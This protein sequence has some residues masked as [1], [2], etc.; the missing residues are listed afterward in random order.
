MWATLRGELRARLAEKW[1]DIEHFNEGPESRHKAYFEVTGDY[2]W[3]QYPRRLASAATDG[4]KILQFRDFPET[5]VRVSRG[6]SDSWRVT[7]FM[8]RDPSWHIAPE[9]THAG[10]DQGRTP[11]RMM[12]IRRFLFA[13]PCECFHWVSWCHLAKQSLN[14]RIYLPPRRRKEQNE[15]APGPA[16]ALFV[17]TWRLM[18]KL[19]SKYDILQSS[20]R[21]KSFL[22]LGSGMRL[23]CVLVLSDFYSA[24]KM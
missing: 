9:N 18:S 20:K 17:T 4:D 24:Q 11:P 7:H 14:A 12:M 16:L 6:W 21:K 10:A 5:R 1:P 22:D 13:L 8:S 2:P 3:P 15:A 19:I 23:N